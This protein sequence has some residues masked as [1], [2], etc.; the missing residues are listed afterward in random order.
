MKNPDKPGR[1]TIHYAE[2]QDCLTGYQKLQELAINN[3]LSKTTWKTITPDERNDWIN[4]T[5]INYQSYQAMGDLDTRKNKTNDGIFRL[6]SRGLITGRDLWAYDSNEYNLYSR[7][8]EMIDFYNEQI[9]LGYETDPKLDPS[10][11]K[12][13]DITK[14]HLKRGRRAEMA[15][16]RFKDVMYRP[17]FVQNVHYDPIF[18]NSHYY[19]DRIFPTGNNDNLVINIAGK[20]AQEFDCF[21][22]RCMGDLHLNG[23]GGQGFPRFIYS[24]AEPRDMCDGQA[25]KQR[26]LRIHDEQDTG[27]GIGAPQS[28]V[29]SVAVSENRGRTARGYL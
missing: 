17:F 3:S 16:F 7:T 14:R 4:K 22:T 2:S 8:Y 25:G 6:Y 11:I 9:D 13:H 26:V 20:S 23:G 19:L 5:N 28:G 24:Y 12:W 10:I 15:D 27:P 18:N 21:M 29:S 1:A